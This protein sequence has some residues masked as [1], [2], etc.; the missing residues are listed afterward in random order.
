MFFEMKDGSQHGL[1]GNAQL[2]FNICVYLQLQ[3][4]FFF[5]FLA[6]CV[7]VSPTAG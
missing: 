5:S 2:Q 4:F 3:A 7:A 1:R 6:C